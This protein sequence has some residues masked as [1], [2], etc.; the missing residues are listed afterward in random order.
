MEGANFESCTGRHLALLR[1]CMLG[2]DVINE[3]TLTR[4]ILL[5]FVLQRGWSWQ[6]RSCR[7][8]RPWC[9]RFVSPRWESRLLQDQ[10]RKIHPW[11]RTRPV[12]ICFIDY[13]RWFVIVQGNKDFTWYQGWESGLA[14]QVPLC[15]NHWSTMMGS[16][17]LNE[18]P[19][20]TSRKRDPERLKFGYS[21]Q[22]SVCVFVFLTRSNFPWES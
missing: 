15:L 1:P 16:W 9:P 18:E 4:P 17:T 12:K 20:G 3:C 22:R 11:K 21:P 10:R 6:L 2:G 8:W 19:T 5:K 7:S 14:C 13:A